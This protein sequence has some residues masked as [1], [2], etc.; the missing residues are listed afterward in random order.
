MSREILKIENLSVNFEGLKALENYNLSLN[1]GTILGVIGPN[2][3]G[4][5]TLFNTIT[6]FIKP[7]AGTIIFNGQELTNK[8]PYRIAEAGISRTFQNICLFENL[9][10]IENVMVGAEL[11]RRENP[12]DVLLNTGRFKKREKDIY[13]RSM[14]LLKLFNL[15]N[16]SNQ[17]A[18]NL[19]YGDRRKL[20]I[21]RA[22]ATSPVLLMVDEPAAGMNPK[23]TSD[24]MELIRFIRDRFEI[25]IILIEH[26]MNLVMPLCERIQVLNYGR[27]I[28]EGKPQ[29][30]QKNEE[31]IKAY[32]GE[33]KGAGG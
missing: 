9:T 25:T 15:E 13:S 16:Y 6:G 12:F 32:L 17:K 18:N 10:V 4:K 28:A 1:E 11:H 31:V 26:N 22:L 23:E 8:E 29:E 24:L 5:T 14:E 27:L 20:E 7:S 19:S 33:E 30:I 2:G 3:A 21:A